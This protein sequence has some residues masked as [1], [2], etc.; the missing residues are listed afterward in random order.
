MGKALT[1]EQKKIQGEIDK[2][3]KKIND[4]RS[5]INGHTNNI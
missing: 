3:N 5:E 2:L 1:D 4:Y